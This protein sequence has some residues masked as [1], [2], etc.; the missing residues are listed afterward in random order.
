MYGFFV[1]V[2]GWSVL[3]VCVCVCVCVCEV[4]AVTW[5]TGQG[6]AARGLLI[7][8]GGA[9]Y[10]CERVRLSEREHARERKGEKN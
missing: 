6:G 3:C 8:V 2:V 1:Q 9:A 7:I 10:V 4:L 5:Q